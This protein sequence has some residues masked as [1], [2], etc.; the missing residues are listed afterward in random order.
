MEALNELHSLQLA[1]RLIEVAHRRER[2]EE[3][4][5]HVGAE[6]LIVLVMDPAI[7]ALIPAQGF[8][9]T[10]PGGKQWAAFL[11]Q[12]ATPGRHV[13]VV[14][15]P[16]RTHV[17]EAVAYVTDD[18]T[19]F[20][21]VGGDAVLS[22]LAQLGVTFLGALLRSEMEGF[23]AAARAAVEEEA[24]RHATM[25]TAAVDQARADAEE[26]RATAENATRAKDEFLAML[27]H[28]LRNPLSPI[29]TALQLMRLR[30]DANLTREQLVIERQVDHLVRLVDDLLDVSRIT[31][32]KVDLKR[33]VVELSQV[34]AKA[35]EIA[36]P[37][38][39]RRSHT[40]TANVPRKGMSVLG[41]STRLSQ[42]VANLLTNAAKYTETGG[43]IS[44]DGE[45][46]E[47]ELVVRV[48]DNG[49]GIAP[50]VLPG[51]FDLFVQAKRSSDRAEGGLGIG[52][53]LVRSLVQMHGGTVVATSDG[54]GLGSEFVLTLP[55]VAAEDTPQPYPAFPDTAQRS[56]DP[57]RVLVVDD[58]VDAVELLSEILREVGHE[59]E[60][61]HD[62]PQALKLVEH[63][64]PQ[65]AIVDI[66]L[67]VMDGY[68]LA[69]KLRERLR[70][71]PLRLI[72]L[73]GYGQEEDRRRSREAGFAHHLV[74]PL[75]AQRLL[76]VVQAD[77]TAQSVDALIP[78]D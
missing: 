74:K 6:A 1:S 58:N 59:V 66:G 7:D 10:L 39:E 36:S 75:D 78:P 45:R 8:Q 56:P 27:G 17:R 11:R 48:K 28:E 32:G 29:V 33:E 54:L 46:N 18:R 14:A 68:E 70:G 71:T 41:D 65:V 21:F 37:L 5:R 2:G 26:A 44:V 4:A 30:G 55:A 60:I 69:L 43:H 22:D 23:A 61:A 57:R 72:A 15:Y 63:F 34:V 16:T 49:I 73:T 3:F 19:A 50:D 64:S 51:I 77:Q 25:L 47:H 13:G 76:D 40:L 9:R 20:V 52:L 53:A 24:A 62:G 38:L 42:V 67:P 12:C 31:Q 35:V